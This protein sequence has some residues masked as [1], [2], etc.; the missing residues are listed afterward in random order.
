MIFQVFHA[1]ELHAQCTLDAPFSR[2]LAVGRAVDWA[3]A[4]GVIS[5]GA[6][7]HVNDLNRWLDEWTAIYWLWKNLGGPLVADETGWVGLAHYRRP[8]PRLL[9][10]T[11]LAL[12]ALREHDVLSWGPQDMSLRAYTDNYSPGALETLFEAI[13]LVHGAAAAAAA[14]RASTVSGTHPFANTFA[15][16]TEGFRRFVAW[17]WPVLERLVEGARSGTP[18]YRTYDLST[19]RNPGYAAERLLALYC[20]LE[21]QRI[22]YPLRCG[23]S[24]RD[25]VRRWV[26]TGER[27]P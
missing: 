14:D 23:V 3:A 25:D 4:K 16:S 13:R 1:P 12:E 9:S 11:G 15:M 20:L 22:F 7:D 17:A 18:L 24:H 8:P 2:P 26:L 27:A 6:G 10:H 19:P 21:G 5:A